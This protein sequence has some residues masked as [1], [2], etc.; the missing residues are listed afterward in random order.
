MRKTY[1]VMVVVLEMMM[2]IFAVVF[3]LV[4]SIFPAQSATNEDAAKTRSDYDKCVYFS[5]ADQLKNRSVH[6][7]SMM[8]ENGFRAC[9][10]EEAV[11]RAF[12]KKELFFSPEFIEA[13]IL[14]IRLSIKRHMREIANNPQIVDGQTGTPATRSEPNAALSQE[15]CKW[16]MAV[17]SREHSTQGQNAFAMEV[18]RN[19]DCFR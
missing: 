16:A 13:S 6:D 17:L 2:R 15:R 3:F 11:L 19:N 4:G 14:K 1:E 5:V 12:M 10:S 18:A 8:T 7:L 9:R